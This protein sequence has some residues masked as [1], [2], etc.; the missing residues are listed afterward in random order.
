MNENFNNKKGRK[1]KETPESRK[2][3]LL[4]AVD[5]NCNPITILKREEIHQKGYFHKT[6]HI[7]LFNKEGESIFKKNLSWLRKTLVCG[8]P[9]LR[10]MCW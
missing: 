1:P 10:D 6:V 3:E 9:L 8:L 7:F 4:E 5:E 2:R